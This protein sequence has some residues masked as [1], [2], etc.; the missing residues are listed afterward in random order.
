M[1]CSVT[2]LLRRAWRQTN[3]YEVV[4]NL[5]N[6]PDNYGTSIVI[7]IEDK[8]NTFNPREGLAHIRPLEIIMRPTLS[9]ALLVNQH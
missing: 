1:S 8:S 9:Q 4:V 2:E 5:G 6:I 7:R 3:I